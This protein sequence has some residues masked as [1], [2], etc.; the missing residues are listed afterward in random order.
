MSSGGKR[1]LASFFGQKAED[2]AEEERGVACMNGTVDGELR[3]TDLPVEVKGCIISYG[4][5]RCGRLRFWRRQH[6]QVREADG[7]YLVIV[8]DVEEREPVQH[9]RFVHWSSLE[10]IME[11]YEYS[12]YDAREHSMSSQQTQIPWMRFFPE[13]SE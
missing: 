5:G 2:Y 9:D 7:V 10:A 11:E 6:K 3:S 1:E 8:Y 12:W 13:I 4:N